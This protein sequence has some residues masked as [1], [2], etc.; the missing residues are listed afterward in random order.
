LYAICN[1]F[2]IK[3]FDK[4]PS[5]FVQ[6]I[7]AKNRDPKLGGNF[8][9]ANLG[10]YR[11]KGRNFGAIQGGSLGRKMGGLRVYI[12]IGAKSKEGRFRGAEL[13]GGKNPLVGE[14]IL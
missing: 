7:G 13:I 2:P 14:P 1:A 8:W 12:K 3:R 10:I 11:K 6:K 9:G 4:K 5:N